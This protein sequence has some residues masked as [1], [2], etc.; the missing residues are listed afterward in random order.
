[1][2]LKFTVYGKQDCEFCDKAIAL[3]TEQNVPFTY[4]AIGKDITDEEFK[5]QFP[6]AFS[7][8]LIFGTYGEK[9]GGYREL[10]AFFATDDFA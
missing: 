2:T 4:V 7:V 1:M 9:I 3:L 8:P 6:Y 10:R 5:E